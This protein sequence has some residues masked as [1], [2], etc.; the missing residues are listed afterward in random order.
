MV[1]Y[2][3]TW[4]AAHDGETETSSKPVM[5][6]VKPD[7]VLCSSHLLGEFMCVIYMDIRK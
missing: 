2:R 7:E 1:C 4:T 5:K 3:N 6:L